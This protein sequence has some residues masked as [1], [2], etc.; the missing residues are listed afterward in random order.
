MGIYRQYQWSSIN[1]HRRNFSIVFIVLEDVWLR[2]SA[3]LWMR[4]LLFWMLCN[5]DYQLGTDVSGQPIGTIKG[6]AVQ[7][8]RLLAP[9]RW[10]WLSQNVSNYP[11]INTVY[12]HRRVK[13]LDD[14]LT[15][16][17]IIAFNSWTLTKTALQSFKMMVNY[18]PPV[19]V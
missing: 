2:A 5:V 7:E 17:S 3:T 15:F 16:R 9:W 10:G 4:S 13:I 12:H 8:E 19:M 14:F 6:Q 18:L 1:V 11:P